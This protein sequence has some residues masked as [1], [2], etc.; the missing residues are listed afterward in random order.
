MSKL[1]ILGGPKTIEETWPQF[2][3][4]R[5]TASVEAAVIKQ[6]HTTVSIYDRSGVFGEFE[7]SFA[8]YH[9]RRHALLSNSG[10]NAIYSMYEG[11]QLGPGDEVICPV[12]TFFA[13][14]SPL[15]HM[16]AIPVFCDCGP[17]GNISPE[18]IE[19][20]ITPRTKAVVVTHMWG[21]PCDMGAIV[22]ICRKHSLRLF[23][24]CSHAHGACV[25]GRVVGSF[26]D[27]A[28]W[29]FQAQKT[30]T[31]G[32]GGIMV[33][34]DDEIY[35]RALLQGHYNKRCKQEIPRDHPLAVF[36]TTGFGLKF[37]AH[38]LAIAMAQEQ[39]THLDEWLAKRQH[40]ADKMTDAFR[41]FP[42]LQTPQ[43]QDRKHGWYAYLMQFDP[44]SSNG[45]GVELFARAVLAEGLL[46]FDRPRSTGTLHEQ[47][48][49]VSPEQALPR[50]YRQSL[51]KNQRS[52]PQAQRFYDQ[53]VK[54]PVWSFDDDES[55]VDLYIQ[56][57]VKVASVVQDD[58]ESLMSVETVL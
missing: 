33:T 4:P 37:R 49:F 27:A 34:N 21:I 40:Y 51:V 24:D 11:A 13:T 44:A 55:M 47:P 41:V 26:G 52:F 25:G 56:G 36:S 1:A 12:Y 46:E 29:S 43:C 53:A 54:L 30:I 22:S 19:Q 38:P 45:V 10:T 5:I 16:G 14:V 58:P 2:V 42:F 35:Y 23:E 20:R 3:W 57:I 9:G 32:E 15:M 48:L 28:A 6:L 8:D 50:L 31:G 17:D 7:T 18:E 39:F